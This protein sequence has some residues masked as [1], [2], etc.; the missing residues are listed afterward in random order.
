VYSILFYNSERRNLDMLKESLSLV[1]FSE[2]AQTFHHYTKRLISY[3]NLC[4]LTNRA[5]T[6]MFCQYK[7]ALQLFKINNLSTDFDEWVHFNTDHVFTTRQV[8]FQGN[9]SAKLTVRLNALINRLHSPN[10]TIPLERLNKNYVQYKI[11]YKKIL[12]FI[13]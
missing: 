10:N 3:D 11:S 8:N 1:I 4:P 9:R 12:S 13:N 6:S 5:T 7:L 2:C